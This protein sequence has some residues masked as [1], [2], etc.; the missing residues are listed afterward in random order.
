M[1]EVLKE[2]KH[3]VNNP[4]TLWRMLKRLSIRTSDD[5]FTYLTDQDV[6]E[7]YDLDGRQLYRSFNFFSLCNYSLE[8]IYSVP[9]F[10]LYERNS[11]LTKANLDFVAEIIQHP[12]LGTRA[13]PVPVHEVREKRRPHRRITRIQPRFMSPMFDCKRNVAGF[14]NTFLSLESVD[15][16][17]HN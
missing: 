1:A 14:I 2:E 17:A 15:I 5:L 10:E 12:E 3:I 8:Q 9:W 7:I 13:T 11:E 16:P 4:N 6:I